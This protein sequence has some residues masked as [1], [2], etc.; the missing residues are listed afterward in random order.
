MEREWAE[1]AATLSI[2]EEYHGVWDD[3]L[4]PAFSEMI[5]RMLEE[6]SPPRYDASDAETGST[7]TLSPV[8]L[9]NRAWSSYEAA[10][11]DYEF[12]EH[13]VVRQFLRR[14]SS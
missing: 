3:T 12:W 14:Q 8:V 11:R 2:E 5:E 4:R 13:R 10:P 1:T 7:S 6:T 9:F